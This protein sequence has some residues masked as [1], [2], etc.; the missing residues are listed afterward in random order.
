MKFPSGTP[1][2]GPTVW[3][4]PKL[5]SS[6]DENSRAIAAL[7]ISSGRKKIVLRTARDLWGPAHQ[8][9]SGRQIAVCTSQ[10]TT[11]S[12]NDIF[13]DGPIWGSLNSSDQ[14]CRPTQRGVPRPF[15]EQKLRTTKRAMGTTAK[16]VK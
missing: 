2:H 1:S 5:G 9:P 14:L 12:R 4:S 10:V 13:S 16:R 3:A 8:T 15:H 6:S 7:D 11:A